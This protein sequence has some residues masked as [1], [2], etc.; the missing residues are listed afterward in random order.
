MWSGGAYPDGSWSNAA[1]WTSNTV[2]AN[3]LTFTNLATAD[4]T[5]SF[6]SNPGFDSIVTANWSI[7]R[8]AI[9]NTGGSFNLAGGDLNLWQAQTSGSYPSVDFWGAGTV[10]VSNNIYV[11]TAT[12]TPTTNIRHQFDVNNAGTMNF[13]GNIVKSNAGPCQLTFRGGGGGTFNVYGAIKWDTNIVSRTDVS[14]LALYSSANTWTQMNLSVGSIILGVNNGLPTTSLLDFNQSSGGA[15]YFRMAD[16]NQTLAQ[17]RC[18]T[19]GTAA[20]FQIVDTGTNTGGTLTLNDN[21]VTNSLGAQISGKGRL[22]KMGTGTLTLVYTNS[23]YTGGTLINAGV[24]QLGLNT[25]NGAITGPIT[26]NSYLVV[27]KTDALTLSSPISG[28]GTLIKTS[29]GTLTLAATNT[30]TGTT[31][32]SNGVLQVTGQLAGGGTMNVYGGTLM[33][34]G[35]IA[36]PVTVYTNVQVM[37]TAAPTPG[38]LTFGNNLTLNPG[39]YITY[40]FGGPTTVGNGANDLLAVGGNLKLNTNPIVLVPVGP[41]TVG[42]SYVIATAASFAG[43]LGSITNPTHYTFSTSVS[44]NQLILTVTGG[45]GASVVWQGTNA[46]WDL[47][48]VNWLASGAAT[49]FYQADNAFF[50]DTAVGFNPSLAT[51]LYPN[52]VTVTTSNTYTFAGSGKLSGATGLT[53]NGPGL[54]AI[55]NANDFTGNVYVNAGTLRVGSATALGVTNGSTTIADGAT[56]DLNGVAYNSPGEFFSI[57]GAGLNGTGAVIN[58]TADQQSG[59]RYLSLATNASIGAWTNRWDVRG[60]GGNASF[61]GGLYLNGYTLTKL[62]TNK[63]ALAD[64]VATNGGSVRIAGGVMSMTRSLVD[65]PGTIDLGTNLLQFENSSTGYVAKPIIS[66]GGR[67][68]LLGNTFTLDSPVTNNGITVDVAAGLTLTLTNVMVGPGSLTQVTT[69]G[70]LWLQAPDLCTGPTVVTAG[71][72]KLDAGSGLPNSP[73]LTVAA[74]ATFD[75]SSLP[76]PFDLG[77]GR[78]LT[79]GGTI[80]GAFTA[81]AGSTVAPGPGAATLTFGG[82]TAFNNSTINFKLGPNP[83]LY[84]PANDLLVVS[85]GSLD[86]AGVTTVNLTPT[87]TLNSTVPYTLFIGTLGTGGIANLNLASNSRYAFTLLDPATTPG[88]IQ[89]QVVG[90]NGNLIWR[91]GAPANPTLWDLKTTQNWLNSGTPDVF[92]SGDTLAFDDTAVQNVA[93]LAGN[94]APASIAMSN[95]ILNYTFA[96]TGSIALGW[97]TNYGSAA[98]TLANGPNSFSGFDMERGQVTFANTGANTFVG[99][100]VNGGALGFGNTDMNTFG[101]SFV[102]NNGSA[103][104]TNAT[105]NVFDA[106]LTIYSGAVTFA[107]GGPNNFLGGFNLNGGGALFT[108]AGISTF[109]P[110]IINAGTLTIANGVNNNFGTAPAIYGTL[111][112]APTAN[113]VATSAF[114]GGGSML[115]QGPNTVTLSGNNAPFYGT[116]EVQAGTVRNGATGGLGGGADIVDNG[117]TIDINGQS[118]VSPVSI[119]IQGTGVTGVGALVNLGADQ[120]TGPKD[121]V[122]AANATIGGTGRMDIRGPGGSG[123]FNGTLDLGGFTLTKAGPDKVSI[124]DCTLPND[125]TIQIT[126]GILTLTR[127]LVGGIEPIIIG[128]NILQFENNTTGSITKPFVASQSRLQVIG[129]TTGIGSWVTNVGGVTLDVATGL[130]FTL[131]NSISGPG[132]VTMTNVG[133]AVLAATNSFTGGVVVQGGVLQL[134]NNLAA[135]TNQTVALTNTTGVTG[136]TGSTLDLLTGVTTPASLVLNANTTYNPDIRATLRAA[137]GAST[138]TGP[139]NLAGDG[140]F[141]LFADVAGTS[142]T[143]N[144]NI[145]GPA[146]GATSVLFI[147][148]ASGT[149]YLNGQVNMIGQLFKTDA[150][151]WLINSVNNV[152]TTAGVAVGTVRL[153]ANNALC[154]TA[155]LTMGQG[156]ANACV[157][158][159]N[160]FSQTLPGLSN[161]GTGTRRIGNDSTTSDAVFTFNGGTTAS[162]YGGQFVDAIT[163]NGTHVLGLTVASGALYLTAV[164]SNTGPTLV[165]SGATLG[166][167]GSLRSPVTVQS[168]GTLFVGATLGTLG[169]SNT[170]VFQSG[171]TNLAKI[172]PTN[173]ACDLVAGIKSVTYGGTLVVT[174]VSGGA[175]TN[176][177]TYKLFAAT[178]YNG[179]FAAIIPATP[180]AGLAWITTNLAVNGTLSV[181]LGVSVTPPPLGWLNSGGFL[182]LSWPSDHTGWRLQCQTN[183]LQVGINTNW[184]TVPGSTTTNYLALPIS[185]TDPTIFYRLTYP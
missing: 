150:G 6:A 115:K 162:T 78:L 74:G 147:R 105:A 154:V 58:A 158:D 64:V 132:S 47:T 170:L 173:G 8:L 12:N 94:L 92:F 54:L 40:K 142:L 175:F 71:T 5:V 88:T 87:A 149:G 159:L 152:W 99:T 130:V 176:G 37:T 49:K 145:N 7:G 106:D 174:N 135:G 70:T 122:L 119:T 140:R 77:A 4:G 44:G 148:G 97:F 21:G 138:W 34:S 143:V 177:A 72:L 183:T 86:I 184:F 83:T 136:G 89:M 113:V 10:G 32:V 131:S 23:T 13:Y 118:S 52:S 164:N 114:N 81:D 104:F 51:A 22:M 50:D 178:N 129:N 16:F 185:T 36:G 108:G 38:T 103:G 157:L 141:G 84:D 61:S 181:G 11:L 17:L 80:L 35:S 68:Q 45:A 73:S 168:G 14:S 79:G 182:T 55:S 53:K 179:A 160:G 59:I 85:G 124:A 98:L 171:A 56:L 123:S 165:Q 121:V 139:I 69:N 116:L 128:T 127:S 101:S 66:S 24:L 67:L 2:P 95:N 43:S 18:D 137:A 169:I 102:V 163:T 180:G 167:T 62:G 60:P 133:T 166:G 111:I 126:N 15:S 146:T 20:N 110:L 3:P 161:T 19:V 29:T 63:T 117:A 25:T 26:N 151:T 112:F 90:A 48:T 134:G 144:G 155:P 46:N 65:G 156:D 39:A 41:L 91:G 107:N 120:Q 82:E 57:A 33:G 75:G 31:T 1:N 100:T 9:T 172:N 42:N 27:N 109:T 153:G 96:G 30:Y 76:A 28:S 93:T 125:G